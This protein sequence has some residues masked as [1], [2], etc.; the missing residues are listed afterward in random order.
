MEVCLAIVSDGMPGSLELTS[1]SPNIYKLVLPG[2]NSLSVIPQR[3]GLIASWRVQGRELLYFD[4]ERFAN[5]GKSVRGGIPIL[6]PICGNLPGNTLELGQ[7]SFPISQHGFARDL[8][9]TLKALDDFL[10]IELSLCFDDNSL[11]HYP[12]PFRLSVRYSLEASSLAITVEVQQLSTGTAA[13]PFSF[14]L[15]PYFA[16]S[17]LENV[18]VEGLPAQCFSHLTMAQ[19]CSQSEIQR[20]PAGI[21]LLAG[22]TASVS[23]IDHGLGS[24]I[25]MQMQPPLDLAVVW[26]DPPRSMVCLEPWTAPRGALATGERCLW[27]QPGE[28]KLL[29]CRYSLV[30]S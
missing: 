8:S 4:H 19:T 2:G 3:G 6:F 14:G 21:D 23:L 24:V 10:G 25:E 30:Q 20:L 18:T 26:S 12:Y 16:V 1:E 29:H 27:L 15:H 28:S 7:R 5:P 17:A 22:P 11:C 9:W 13:M